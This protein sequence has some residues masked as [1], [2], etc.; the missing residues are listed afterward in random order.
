MDSPR[1]I[2]ALGESM[3]GPF[4]PFSGTQRSVTT[5]ANQELG[6]WVSGNWVIEDQ[7][8]PLRLN[9]GSG[10]R[11]FGSAQGRLLAGF[12]P[13]FESMWPSGLTA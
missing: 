12:W 2:W 7:I 5:R 6:N 8:L 4:T 13:H 3:A 11:P 10:F 1:A 9:S